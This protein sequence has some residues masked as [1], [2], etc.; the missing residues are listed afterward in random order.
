MAVPQ[1]ISTLLRSWLQPAS[2]AH[3]TAQYS[4]EYG[5]RLP[6]PHHRLSSCHLLKQSPVEAMAT[7]LDGQ[8]LGLIWD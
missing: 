6:S 8:G 2:Q 3:L 1:K 4:I 5:V 7:T